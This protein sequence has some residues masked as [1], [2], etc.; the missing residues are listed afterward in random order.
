MTDLACNFLCVLLE[1]S[2][3]ILSQMYVTWSNE[4]ENLR[5]FFLSSLDNSCDRKKVLSISTD[6]CLPSVWNGGSA[7]MFLM[8]FETSVLMHSGYAPKIQ[9]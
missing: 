8:I 4:R 1:L 7:L 5:Y 2:G 9:G 3:F 6:V